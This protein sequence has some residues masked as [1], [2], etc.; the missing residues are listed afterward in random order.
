MT[1]QPFTVEETNLSQAWAKVMLR[2]LDKGVTEI[3]PLVVT[4]QLPQGKPVES[5]EIRRVADETLER[6][7]KPLCDTTANTIFPHSYWTPGAD[8]QQLF[9][10]YSRVLPRLRKHTLNQHRPN[11]YGLYFER[12]MAHGTGQVNQLKHIIETWQGGN[13]RRS[14][15]QAVIFDPVQDHTHQRMRGFP[16]LQQVTFAPAPEGL[17]VMGFYGVQYIFDRAYGNY[18]GLCRLG[19]FM[20]Y[21]MGLPLV[22]MLCV[23][24]IA[25]LGTTTKAHL[26]DM[27]QTLQ[28]ILPQQEDLPAVVPAVLST[29][30][31]P[32]HRSIAAKERPP[33]SKGSPQGRIKRRAKPGKQRQGKQKPERAVARAIESYVGTR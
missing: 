7:E 11:Q 15:L 32:A 23:T 1:S 26:K 21:E 29:M 8:R 14:A 5:P 31:S 10:R 22:R 16:C 2:L 17:T 18:L 9:D 19:Q 13:H 33:S 12:L 30:P 20:A 3:Q 4:I 28:T 24:G 6:F 25:E 27:A